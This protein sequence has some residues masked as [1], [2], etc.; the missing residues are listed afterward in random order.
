V[1]PSL[2]AEGKPL[3]R[4]FF[5]KAYKR[6]L[7]SI[8]VPGKWKGAEVAPEGYVNEQ[9]KRNLTFHGLRHTFVTHGRLA[10]I[11]DLEIQALAGHKSSAMTAHY[12]HAKQVI[13]FN[14][15]REKLEAA[16]RPQEAM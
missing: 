15:T 13:D 14:Q 6:E 2:D 1:F 12:S 3:C 16:I 9:E 4:G 10:G 7:E 11:S 8:G 5:E